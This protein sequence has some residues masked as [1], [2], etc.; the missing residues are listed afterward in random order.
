MAVLRS[1][2]EIAFGLLYL[3]N[4]I[5]FVGYLDQH[6]A[7]HYSRFAETAWLPLS[8]KLIRF[9]VMPHARGYAI[10][11]LLISTLAAA[12]ILSRGA[13]V[14]PGLIIGAAYAMSG[15]LLSE[16]PGAILNLVLAAIPALLAFS[17]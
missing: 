7:E 2:V 9:V 14:K 8:R 6:T 11:Q 10:L 3:I 12:L 13:F 1:I 16:R 15:A 17:R 4:A 5:L